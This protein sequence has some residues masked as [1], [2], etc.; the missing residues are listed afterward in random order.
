MG[1]NSSAGLAQLLPLPSSIS[2]GSLQNGHGQKQ[3]QKPKVGA[4]RLADVWDEEDELFDIGEAS[5]GET[6]PQVHPAT[7][8]GKGADASHHDQTPKIVVTSSDS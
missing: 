6:E 5:E 1:P 7:S 2:N 8:E 3:K 4:I